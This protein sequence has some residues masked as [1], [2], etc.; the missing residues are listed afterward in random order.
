VDVMVIGDVVFFDVCLVL[1]VLRVVFGVIDLL[2]EVIVLVVLVLF[3][4]WFSGS[5]DDVVVIVLGFVFVV[6]VIFGVLVIVEMLICGRI[7]GKFVMGMCI[8]CD[9]GGLIWFWY[10]LVCGLVGVVEIWMLYGVFVL[11]CLLILL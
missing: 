4:V 10:V 2:V 5:L 1:F 6:G 7:F 3:T 11:V 8:V 9:D